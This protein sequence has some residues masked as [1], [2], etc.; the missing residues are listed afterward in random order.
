MNIYVG[1]LSR[2]TTDESLRKAFEA[3]GEVVSVRVMKDK[4]TGEPRGFAFVEMKT[5]DD[6]MAAIEGLNGKSL[7]GSALRVSQARAPEKRPQFGGPRPQSRFN[8][9]PRRY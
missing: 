8:K 6:A 7:E 3:Y 4:F 1:N 9:P 5:D 2:S